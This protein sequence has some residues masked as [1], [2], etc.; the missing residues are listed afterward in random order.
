M[1]YTDKDK[2]RYLKLDKDDN[3]IEEPYRSEWSRDLARL[4]H[5]RAF[6]QLQGKTQLLPGQQSDFYRNRLTHS[7][8]VAQVAKSIAYKLNY[9]LKSTGAGYEIEPEICEF[10]ALAHDIGRPPFGHLGEKALNLKMKESG[11]FEG[12]AQTF[13]ILT[14]LAK[15]HLIPGTVYETGIT[16]DGE[17]KRVGLNLTYRTL[18]SVIKYDLEIPE[19]S[20]YDHEE[21][22]KLVKGYYGTEQNIIKEI[23]KAITGNENAKNL[24]TI[25]SS[26]LD[27]ADD[28]AYAT[29]D[30][31]DAF[32]IGYVKPIDVISVKP[33]VIENITKKIN[34]NLG[35]EYHIDEILEVYFSLFKELFSPP[36]D[37]EGITLTDNEKE[38]IYTSSLRM[39]VQASDKI[40]MNGYYRVNFISKLIGRFIRS[41]SID[42]I[43]STTPALSTIKVEPRILLE[44]EAL[45]NYMYHIQVMHPDLRLVNHR[46]KEVISYIF[47]CFTD[48]I[49][50]PDLLPGDVR[51]IYE[52]AINEMSRKRAV[53]DYIAGLSDSQALELYNRLKSGNPQFVFKSL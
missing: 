1:Q 2:L 27:I 37:T 22:V 17:D 36:I 50:G 12:N 41:V 11:G 45:K 35:T 53:C 24:R 32:K 40:A 48:K 44:I 19:K 5:S 8:E 28:I 20:H 10:A 30:L 13:R 26:I 34:R 52:N 49:N 43:D 42:K 9:D 3:S 4:I 46:G 33:N 29:Y 18:A 47:D 16:S 15:K 51:V 25:E 38:I 31:D 6:K 21:N 23:K 39:S 14:K 7:L